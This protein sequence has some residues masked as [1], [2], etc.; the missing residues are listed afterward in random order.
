MA[1]VWFMRNVNKGR[2]QLLMQLDDL[3][4]HLGAQLGIQIGQRLI[5]QEYRRVA[6]HRTSER[7]TLP[8]TAR[9]LL[10]AC[11]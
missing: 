1:S 8:L 11:G 6:H 4:A 9:K 7:D 2:I 5:E 3:G 10:W